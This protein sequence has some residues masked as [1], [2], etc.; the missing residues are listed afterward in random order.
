MA[1]NKPSFDIINIE[2]VFVIGR[3]ETVTEA[4]NIVKGTN[5]V[6]MG[7]ALGYP[8]P[9]PIPGKSVHI[10]DVAMMHVRSLDRAIVPKSEDF[11]ASCNPPQGIVWGTAFDILAK[12]YPKEC[13][14]G[15]F[16]L[17]TDRLQSGEGNVDSSKAEKTFGF[18][19][20]SYE[21]QVISVASHYLELL[22]QV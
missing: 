6:V 9:G 18:T 7:P 11:L 15:I 5:G 13:T 21:E 10:D 14:D 3:D 12:H 1:K 2:P 8:Q 17:D 4:A 20:K 19:F 22:G 16:K